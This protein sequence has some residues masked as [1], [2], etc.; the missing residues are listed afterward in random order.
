[1]VV[2]QTEEEKWDFTFAGANIDAFTASDNYGIQ[3][4]DVANVHN[5]ALAQQ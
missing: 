3:A 1:M 4:K 2:R 5:N